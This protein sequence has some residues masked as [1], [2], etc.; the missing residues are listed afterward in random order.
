MARRYLLTEDERRSLF[1]IPTDR[2]SLAKYYSVTA[3][4]R[5]LI[6]VKRKDVNRLGFAMHLALL[7]HPGFGFRIEDP[8]PPEL[9]RHIA[10]ELGV[11]ADLLL[12][13]PRRA[14]TRFEHG[15]EAAKLL[16]LRA[17]EGAD[18]SLALDLAKSAALSTD[19]GLPIATAIVDGLR[20]KRIILPAPARIERIGVARGRGNWPQTRSLTR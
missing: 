11:S 17:F 13:Y 20:D 4:E 10:A 8:V 1:D 9:I 19:Q 14:Q 5:T 2:A 12:A 16:G 7:R 6:E 15:W 18:L 3:E